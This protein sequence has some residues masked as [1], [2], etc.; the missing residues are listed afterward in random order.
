MEQKQFVYTRLQ[1]QLENIIKFYRIK[2]MKYTNNALNIL[3][4]KTYKGIGKAW[5]VK[6]IRGNED[7]QEILSLLNNH[8]KDMKITLEELQSRKSRCMIFL[9]KM[10]EHTDGV[11]A[12]G[13]AD[14]PKHRGNVKNSEKPIALFYRGDL[15]LLNTTHKNIAVIGVLSPDSSTEILEQE[16]VAELVQKG[17]VIV[18][19]LAQGCDAI[20][21]KQTIMSHGKTVAVLPSPLNNIMPTVNRPLAEEVIATGGLLI[22]EYYDEPKSKME[23]NGRYQERDRL[24]A[25]FSDTII[26]ASS[27]AKNDLGNDSGSR[28]AME[29]A[30]TYGIHRAVMYNEKT[31]QD[32]PKYDLNRQIMAERKD[33]IVI[34]ANNMKNIVGNLVA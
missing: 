8:L 6:N 11:T 13:D 1:K 5:I 33:T 10:S 3:V 15:T 19:G 32:N 29:Y 25:L 18:S 22:S 31:D 14:F 9:D 23:L 34:N 4:A 27:Y 30:L 24:Q 17:A 20:A 28:L 21:H 2:N 12:L 16:L 26:L 7:D